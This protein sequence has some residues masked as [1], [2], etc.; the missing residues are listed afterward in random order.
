MY[1][2]S[3][4]ANAIVDYRTLLTSSSPNEPHP[5]PIQAALCLQNLPNKLGTVIMGNVLEEE[6]GYRN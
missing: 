6:G 5:L 2:N 1:S 3:Q 4:A